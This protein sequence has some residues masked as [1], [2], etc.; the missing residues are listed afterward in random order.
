MWDNAEVA[1][2]LDADMRVVLI[3][4]N[5][6]EAPVREVLGKRA[7]ELINPDSVPVFRQAFA[8]VMRGKT[9]CVT[10][11]ATADAGYKYW[12]KVHFTPSP[13]DEAP[14]LFH[15][16]RLPR[17]WETLSQREREVIQALHAEKMNPK[18]AAR[19][20]NMSVHTLNAH[21][22]SICKKCDLRFI[23]DFWVFVERCR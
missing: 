23:G 12:F 1:G 6:D 14:V 7:D 18:R 17:E 16:R 20:L 3:S 10:L 4:R 11:S 21:R 2:L 5:E 9:R 19:A 22:R 15:F 13:A 8:D